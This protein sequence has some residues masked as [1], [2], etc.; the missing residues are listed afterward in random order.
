MYNQ[1]CSY[2]NLL[3]AYKKARKG[4]T[5]RRY[6]KRFEEDL[7]NKIKLLREELQFLTYKPHRLKVFILREPKTRKISKSAFRDRVIHHALCNLI[8][9]IF[10]KSF[11]YDSHANQIG[12][13]THKALERFDKFKRKVSKNNTLKC[14]CLKADI[15]HYFKD[16][17]HDVL[18]DIIS[19]KIKDGKVFWLIKRILANLPTSKSG[20]ATHSKGMPL[21]NLTSQF[22]ANVYL[23]ELD[24]F[25]K[26]K[27]KAKYY[28]RYVDD[29]VI[30]HNSKKQ[31]EN[32]KVK[33]DNFLGLKL[34]IELHKDKSKVLSL[35]K[36]VNFLGFR[37]FY[38]HK[39][40]RKSNMN[41]F[42]RKFN[43]L[44]IMYKEGLITREKAVE[45]FEGWLTYA[46]CANTFKHR[47]YRIKLFNKC[48]KIDKR[49]NNSKK[50]LNFVR[51][52]KESEAKFSIQKTFYLFSKRLSIKKIAIKRDI[53]ESTV[54]EH[55]ANL[56][57]HKQIS[58]FNVLS[59][60]RIFKIYSKI[61]NKKDKLKDIKSR[62]KYNSITFDEINCVLA[63]IKSK[64]N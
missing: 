64:S 34:K 8:V 63:C 19:K 36:G 22:F 26:H 4:K 15:K 9:P 57:E 29:F 62:I 41:N 28:I 14:Y 58:V 16:V 24:Y 60:K 32:W 42:E 55:L 35:E 53:K 1:L 10:E 49:I 46:T 23:N 61:R 3:L 13:G 31:L 44:K 17:D 43:E 5:K 45:S 54:W 18:L 38:Y 7:I 21:G 2:E 48:F 40:L 30:L 20:G 51:K 33:I 39:L 47:K 59:K 56:I 6:V 27:L 50:I 12:K 11:I 25:V 52:I 37:I